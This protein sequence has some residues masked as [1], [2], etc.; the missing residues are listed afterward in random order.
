[1]EKN[2][3]TT[4]EERKKREKNEEM[5]LLICKPKIMVNEPGLGDSI[6]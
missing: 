6:N 2:F 3:S 5:S 1:M 4:K